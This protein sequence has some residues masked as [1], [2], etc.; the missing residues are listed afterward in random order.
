MDKENRQLEYKEALTKQYLKTVS[1]FSNYDGGNII[2]GIS[3][4]L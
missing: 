3:D 4:D 2:F 1:A